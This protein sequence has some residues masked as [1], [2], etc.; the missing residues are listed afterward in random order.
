MKRSHFPLFRK[1]GVGFGFRSYI[2][3]QNLFSLSPRI[4]AAASLRH[5]PQ[6]CIDHEFRGDADPLGLE[7]I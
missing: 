5:D 4:S 1:G 7:N 3:E 2:H 6:I